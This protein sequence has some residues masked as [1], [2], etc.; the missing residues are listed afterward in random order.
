MAVASPE[1]LDRLATLLGPGT[2]KAYIQDS[3]ALDQAAE[4]MNALAATHTQG[5]IGIDVS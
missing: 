1:N 3:Y 2:I 4:A 5:K